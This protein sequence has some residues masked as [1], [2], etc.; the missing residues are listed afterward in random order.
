[1]SKNLDDPTYW[2]GRAS[3]VRELLTQISDQEMKGILEEIA[4]GYE[5]IAD[6]MIRSSYKS[7]G[8]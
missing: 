2:S 4:Q 3:D 7:N 1:M 6:Q 5:R 8:N